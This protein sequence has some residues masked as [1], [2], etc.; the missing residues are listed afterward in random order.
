MK[1]KAEIQKHRPPGQATMEY[2]ILSALVGIT[3]LSIVKNYG[4]VLRK[5]FTHVKEK[6]NEIK[7]K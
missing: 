2:I 5:H 6:L 7:V 1:K 3:C 4:V